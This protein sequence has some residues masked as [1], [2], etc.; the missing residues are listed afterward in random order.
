MNGEERKRREEKKMT[1]PIILSPFFGREHALTP[2]KL[3]TQPP[4]NGF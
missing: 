2:N 4:K 1:T 3:R